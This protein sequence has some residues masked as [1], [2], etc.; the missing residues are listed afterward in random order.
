MSQRLPVFLVRAG[1]KAGARKL[2]EDLL[3]VEA[4]PLYREQ[5][6]LALEDLD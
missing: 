1:D 6:E 3:A 2:L 4:V 5:I